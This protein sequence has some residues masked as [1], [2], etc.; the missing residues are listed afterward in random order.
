METI[1][2]TIDNNKLNNERKTITSEVTSWKVQKIATELSV[3][4]KTV[5]RLIDDGVLPVV[6][7]RG[8]IRVPKQAVLD[9]L[10]GQTRYNSGCVGTTCASTGEK[11]CQSLNVVMEEVKTTTSISKVHLEKRLNDLL[12]PVTND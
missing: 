12:E 4:I 11:P 2:T 3:S 6:R 1:T 10:K 9:W 8:C 5:K 7:I